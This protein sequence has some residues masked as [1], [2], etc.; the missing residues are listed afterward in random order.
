MPAHMTGRPQCRISEMSGGYCT[1]CLARTHGVPL[2]IYL[3]QPVSTLET[4]MQGGTGPTGISSIVQ[5]NLRSVIL[6]VDSSAAKGAQTPGGHCRDCANRAH[7]KVVTLSE[8]LCFCLLRALLSA[9]KNP[10]PYQ[11]RTPLK[12]YQIWHLC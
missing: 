12:I 10:C 8:R 11:F 1:S 2:L 6:G 3:A 4:E 9:P 5:W 7:E